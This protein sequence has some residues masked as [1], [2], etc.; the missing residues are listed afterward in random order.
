METIK[1]IADAIDHARAGTPLANFYAD[2]AEIRGVS[3]SRD[4]L[5]FERK[6]D[7]APRSGYAYH[8]GGRS[9]LQL[10]I[11]F[12]EE[13]TYFR[14]GAAFSIEKGPYFEDPVG[15]LGPVIARFN[16]LLPQYPALHGL[17][18]W[19]VD[20]REPEDRRRTQ[21]G[22]V[23]A[24]S[25]DLIRQG[26]FIFFGESVPVSPDG[27]RPDVIRRAVAVLNMIYPLYLAL[28]DESSQSA[29][30]LEYRVARICWN[31]NLWTHPSGRGGKSRN[32]KAFEH[33]H[34]FG[35]EEWLFDL[36]TTLN[37][38]KHG[39]IQPMNMNHDAYVGK[40]FG[41]LLYTIDGATKQRYW[42]GAIDGVQAITAEVARNV[43]RQFKR[44]G[45]LKNM[46]RQVA[47]LGLATEPVA[48]TGSTELFNIRFRPSALR[49]F[50][51]PIPFPTDDVP[52]DYYNTLQRVPAQWLNLIDPRLPIDA[53]AGAIAS[54]GDGVYGDDDENDDSPEAATQVMRGAYAAGLVDL[55]Q[56]QWQNELMKT[57]RDDLPADVKAKREAPVGR[58]R[59]DVRLRA[60][61]RTVFIE[62]KPRGTARSVIREALAQLLDYAYWP[63]VSRCDT[64][65]IVGPT[66]PGQEDQDY[67]AALRAR[68]AIPVHYLHYLDGRIVGIGD[69]YRA[70][71]ATAG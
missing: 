26:I 15:V 68:F 53:D 1:E 62:L 11:G 16:A 54:K 34:G 20:K 59:V 12:E 66:P 7:D 36:G 52:S 71:P 58:Y 33:D 2:R 69:W 67:L 70:L 32:K 37:G 41:L 50:E 55:L 18:M 22:T 43:A 8:W 60:P 51:P 44:K 30:P 63:T 23:G 17:Q 27:V 49:V 24:I 6:D 45:W 47:A 28:L 39:F 57:L 29:Q 38:Y 25:G 56:M 14:Y 9:E 4:N 61:D 40:R 10:N 64:L 3:G 42:A 48:D 21:V 35:H 46:E 19:F 5:F 13:H 31:T 65:L